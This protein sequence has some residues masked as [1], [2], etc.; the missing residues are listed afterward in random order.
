MKI[1][2]K[3]IYLIFI[4]QKVFL[5]FFISKKKKTVKNAGAH[6][7]V[8]VLAAAGSSPLAREELPKILFLYLLCSHPTPRAAIAI[9]ILHF[10]YATHHAKI[11]LDAVAPW[12]HP[13][14]ASI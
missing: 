3:R 11:E 8:F 2:I 5:N 13:L 12:I 10:I 1:F 14:L 6:I 7:V 9:A 4:K